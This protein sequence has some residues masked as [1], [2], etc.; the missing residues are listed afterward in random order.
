M[1][2]GYGDC[3]STLPSSV[4]PPTPAPYAS[5]VPREFSTVLSSVP[6]VCSV[7]LAQY[8]ENAAPYASSVHLSERVQY[9]SARQY[10]TAHS[11]T[12]ST[13]VAVSTGHGIGNA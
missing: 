9:Y 7:S 2:K 6:L 10:Q 5:S 8:R 11:S 1:R 13:M 4:A 3:T 12:R